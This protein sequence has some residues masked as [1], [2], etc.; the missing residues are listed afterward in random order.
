MKRKNLFLTIIGGILFLGSQCEA[1][2]VTPGMSAIRKSIK[3]TNELYFKLFQK[4]DTAIVNLYTDDASLL[5]P[6]MLPIS[7]REAL[8]RDF[9]D[10]FAAGKIEG[11]KFQTSSIYGEGK[12]FVT[13]EGT[14]QVFDRSGKLLDDG[15][16]LKLWKM[17]KTGWKIFKDSINSN[18]K[19]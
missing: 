13:E 18:H 1:Q 2:L 9:A 4:N 7:G 12:G 14:W 8:K 16:Y 10:T 6:N 5:A 17:T 11:V 3:S 15:K 19:I